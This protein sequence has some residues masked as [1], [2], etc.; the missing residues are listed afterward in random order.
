[1]SDHNFEQQVQQSLEQL[2]LRPSIAVWA[3][4]EKNIRK[5]KRRRRMI[6][7]LPICLLFLGAGGFF[8]LR[9]NH[10]ADQSA[11]VA[12]KT[13]P[14]TPDHTT[15]APNTSATENNS[16]Q[17]KDN[18]T[19][20]AEEATNK[21]QQ[22]TAIPAT[23][24]PAHEVKATAPVENGTIDQKAAVTMAKKP[25][26]ETKAIPHHTVVKQHKKNTAPKPLKKKD[27]VHIDYQDIS[28]DQLELTDVKDNSINSIDSTTTAATTI[29]ADSMTAAISTVDSTT[30]AIT[31]V[32]PDSAAL[33]STTPVDSTAKAAELV[34][35]PETP[36][37]ATVTQKDL[38]LQRPKR[39]RWQ[40]GVQA[41]AGFS[42]VTRNGLL[43]GLFNFLNSTTE[44]NKVADVAAAPS[45]NFQ[46]A[47]NG[48]ITYAP[49]F[50]RPI[51]GPSEITMGPSLSVGAFVQRTFSKRFSLSAGVQYAYLST[52]TAV[53]SKVN[54]SRAVNQANYSARL[55]SSYYDANN[56][57][58]YTNRYH[59]IE[60]PV[61]L[62]TKLNKSM[63]VP[64]TW[65]LGL[66][67]AKM[68]GT[69]ALHYDGYGGVYY[70]DN[71]LFNKTQWVASTGFNIGLFQQS[72]HPLAIGPSLRYNMT[73]M[74]KKEYNINQHLWS[75]GLKATVLLKK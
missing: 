33:A 32:T 10:T 2:K 47:T 59:F 65:D 15:I 69:T 35:Q 75:V 3:E 13:A 45:Q 14:S 52:R 60:L 53:G 72:K 71:S 19:T 44:V 46:G 7:W 28:A 29:A 17:T 41:E 4:V 56:T 48:A 6:M 40:W 22:S 20:T 62:H 8:M 30:M 25:S 58:D 42:G 57:E 64:I 50:P 27:H 12:N 55:V 67:F 37:Q 39:G 66:S 18:T 31:T 23:T 49:Q 1:M 51:N 54:N 38:A 73:N 61:T 11:V 16:T 36:A 43:G 34:K 9:D 21:T 26:Q 24:E 70:K 5:D 74:L 63:R 68:V